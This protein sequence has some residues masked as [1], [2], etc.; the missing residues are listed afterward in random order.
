MKGDD[1]RAERLATF[2]EGGPLADDVEVL[3]PAVKRVR[4]LLHQLGP[5]PDHVAKLLPA[6]YDRAVR[7]GQRPAI[8]LAHP[9]LYVCDMQAALTFYRDALGLQVHDEG[10]WFSTLDAGGARVALHWT[11]SAGQRPQIGDI[12]LEFRTDD[13]DGAVLALREHGLTVEVRTDPYR[14][15]RYA[16]VQDP[17]GHTVRLSGGL[18]AVERLPP[19]PNSVTAEVTSGESS[20]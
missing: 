1:I 6:L 20:E 5:D 12:R 17:D 3:V 18:A 8:A 13:L 7:A 4:E 19:R 10:K 9:T 15:E 2:L 11:G 14:R 16:T